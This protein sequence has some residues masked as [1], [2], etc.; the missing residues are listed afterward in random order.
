MPFEAQ[1]FGV[2][3]TTRGVRDL[4][5][6]C[7]TLPCPGRIQAGFP[8]RGVAVAKELFDLMEDTEKIS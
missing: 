3:T 4:V 7:C 8:D 5:E 1:N 2:N 6:N